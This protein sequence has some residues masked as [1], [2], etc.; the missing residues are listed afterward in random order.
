MRDDTKLAKIR[1]A[2][3]EDRWDDALRLAARFQRLGE[4]D[5][6][7]RRGAEA[8]IRPDFYRQIGQDPELL[9]LKGIE[10]LK[11]R[12]SSSWKAVHTDRD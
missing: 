8:V 2:M 7:I 10:A 6:P 5:E 12:F 1:Q 3:S 9:K 4:H 11:G